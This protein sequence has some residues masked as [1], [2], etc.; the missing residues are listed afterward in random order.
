MQSLQIL[1]SRTLKE[2]AQLAATI[3]LFAGSMLAVA[4]ASAMANSAEEETVTW[5]DVEVIVFRQADPRTSETWP[6]DTGVPAIDGIRP[7]FATANSEVDEIPDAVLTAGLEDEEALPPAAP[8][9]YEPL[10]PEEFQMQGIY[11]SLTRSSRYEPLLHAAWTQPGVSSDEAL[12]LRITMPDAFQREETETFGDKDESRFEQFP[13][14][15]DRDA[16]PENP[17]QSID[18]QMPERPDLKRPL[19]G[20]ILVYVKTYLHVNLDLIYLP[21]DIN[22]DILGDAQLASDDYVK[23]LQEQREQRKRAILEALARGDMTLDEAEIMTLEPKQELFEGFRL[24]AKRRMRSREIHYF[25][26][27]VFGVITT[28][29]PREITL[30]MSTA[31]SPA[32]SSSMQ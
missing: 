23:S 15:T 13:S 29:T 25:D 24:Q 27:P 19:D 6:A 32:A 26:H 30:S 21:E 17:D 1:R 7:L 9:P 16:Q 4:P 5:Y 28:I 2:I 18:V 22:P 12:P 3:T 31:A 8:T 11:D 14:A 20:S 10:P